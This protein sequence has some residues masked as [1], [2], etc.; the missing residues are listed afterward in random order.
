VVNN[1]IRRLVGGQ[2]GSVEP[3]RIAIAPA[4]RKPTAIN[5]DFGHLSDVGPV[6]EESGGGVSA[7]PGP[8][9]LGVTSG[10]GRVE[11]VAG[12]QVTVRTRLLAYEGSGLVLGPE[13]VETARRGVGGVGLAPEVAVNDVASL[14]WDWVCDRLSPE[15]LASMKRCTTANLAAVNALPR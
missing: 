14:H 7:G 9:G 4:L 11:T 6:G 8:P 1:L 13:E 10:R 12:D 15:G 5:R 2:L 3:R